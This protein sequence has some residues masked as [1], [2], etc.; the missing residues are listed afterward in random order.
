MMQGK[1][2]QILAVFLFLWLNGRLPT[3]AQ[4][5]A[6]GYTVEIAIPHTTDTSHMQTT[7]SASMF[8]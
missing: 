1:M 8:T 4:E 7:S 2:G 3:A 5:T 6:V